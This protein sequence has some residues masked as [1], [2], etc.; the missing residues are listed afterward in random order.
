MRDGAVAGFKYFDCRSIQ[1]I[2]VCCRGQASGRLEISDAPDF[3][4][5][6]GAADIRPSR[7]VTW[8]ETSAEIPDG[9]RALYFRFTGEGAVD[10]HAFR[11]ET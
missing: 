4:V 11:L 8:S 3:P 2:A 9:V 10:F 1:R 6:R 5:I 7:D